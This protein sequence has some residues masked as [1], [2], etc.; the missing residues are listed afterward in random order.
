MKSV[1]QQEH[2]KPLEVSKDYVLEYE[3]RERENAD[4]L[5][6]QVDRHISTL[7]ALRHRLEDRSDLKNRQEE[8]RRWQKEFLPKKQ[9]VLMGK[10]LAEVERSPTSHAEDP[11]ADIDDDL[12]QRTINKKSGIHKNTTQELNTVLDSLNRLA[13]LEHRISSL[14]EENRYDELM[15]KESPTADQRTAFD[16][17]KKRTASGG[18]GVGLTYEVRQKNWKVNLPSGPGVAA[19][20]ARQQ[21]QQ[22]QV[23]AQQQSDGEYDLGEDSVEVGGEGGPGIFITAQASTEKLNM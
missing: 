21:Q 19:A 7:K 1:I 12:I 10:T 3:R 14:E 15:A 17:R 20:R 11:D 8:Y 13:D 16:F 6:N 18:G 5:A 9:A 4:R 23:Q 2:L 22:Q